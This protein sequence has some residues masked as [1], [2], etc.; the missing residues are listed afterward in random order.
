[1]KTLLVTAFLAV[2]I[3]A[4]SSDTSSPLATN[5]QGT[6]PQG[7][8][9]SQ[10]SDC[11]PN[12]GL[13][14]GFPVN[15]AGSTCPTTGVCVALGPYSVLTVCSCGKDPVAITA[16]VTPTYSSAP[17]GPGPCGISEDGGGTTT[18]PPSTTDAAAPTTGTDASTGGSKTGG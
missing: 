12:G 13:S 2:A 14:C 9:C 5:S 18:A 11:E 15:D 7:G 8:V 6:I 17:I 1:M 10:T 4:C 16:N 3:S